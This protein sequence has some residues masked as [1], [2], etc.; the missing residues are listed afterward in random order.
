[1]SLNRSQVRVQTKDGCNDS[2]E[3]TQMGG[4]NLGRKR[5]IKALSWSQAWEESTDEYPQGPKKQCGVTAP[6]TQYLQAYSL[7][8]GAISIRH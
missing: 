5:E 1:M 6:W 7:G 3:M 2:N 8:S 4:K